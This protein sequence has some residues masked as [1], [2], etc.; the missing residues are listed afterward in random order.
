MATIHKYNTFLKTQMNG[1][2]DTTGGSSSNAARVIDFATNTLKIMLCSSSYSPDAATHAC[3]NSV[4]NEVTGSGYTAGG[5]T[6][7]GATVT[8][9]GGTVTFDA[10]DV[11]WFES[12]GGFSNARYAVIYKDTGI[13]AT[14]TLFAYIDL[15]SDKGNADADLV[16]QM[17]ALGIATWV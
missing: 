5:I 10:N 7:T 4:T 8:L 15:I 6:L 2:N 11:T 12:V 17:N 13:A 16:I 1:G 9:S 14:S 3:K